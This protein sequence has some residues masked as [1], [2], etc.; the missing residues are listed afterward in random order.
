MATMAAAEVAGSASVAIRATTGPA[1]TTA[2]TAR[3]AAMMVAGFPVVIVTAGRSAMKV[4]ASSTR[5]M[6]GTAATMAAVM[7]AVFAKAAMTNAWRECAPAFPIVL[8]ENVA[9]TVAAAVAANVR[10]V[11]SVRWKGFARRPALR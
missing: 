3:F 4:R 10:R 5:V 11:L 8:A 6:A 9:M 2:A 1:S 7:S